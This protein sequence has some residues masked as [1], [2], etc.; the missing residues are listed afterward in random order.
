M[1]NSAYDCKKK[2]SSAKTHFMGQG[3]ILQCLISLTL[4]STEV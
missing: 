4:K 2:I 1:D 3:S